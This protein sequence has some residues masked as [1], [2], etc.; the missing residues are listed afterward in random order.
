MSKIND[1][2]LAFPGKRNQQ[3]GKVSDFGFSDDDSPTFDYVEYP[4]MTLRDYFAGKALAGAL[5]GEPGPHLTP[6][7]V[8][9]DSYAIA[10]LMIAVRGA[11]LGES[12]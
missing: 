10:D 9:R 7:R 1:G 8:T 11:S 12:R 3:V 2:G 6:E 4:G 5:A